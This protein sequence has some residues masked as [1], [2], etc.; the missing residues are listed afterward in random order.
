MGGFFQTLTVAFHPRLSTLCEAPTVSSR[1]ST[2]SIRQ[3]RGKARER[4]W[5]QSHACPRGKGLLAPGL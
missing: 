2:S 4:C 5:E 3:L 1:G